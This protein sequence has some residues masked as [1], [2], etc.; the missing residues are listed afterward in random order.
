[1]GP[2]SR[3][4]QSGSASQAAAKFATWLNTDPK[5][6]AA[7]V[8]EAGVYP[9]ATAA[10]SSGALTTPEFFPN[11]PDFYALAADIAKGTA[12]AGW[13]PNVNVAYNTFKDAFGKAATEKSS[14]PAALKTVQETTVADMKKNGFK[15]EG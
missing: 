1:M 11:Q 7:L 5:A 10:Q 8:K 4:R 15:I 6:I 2:S 14:F 3:S 12:A 13:G 9:A